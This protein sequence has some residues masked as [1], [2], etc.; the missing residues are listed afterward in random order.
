MRIYKY[1]LGDN[2]IVEITMPGSSKIL[3]VDSQFNSGFLW[4]LVNDYSETEVRKFATYNTG[5]EIPPEFVDRYIGTYMTYDGN[6]VLHVFE[7][8]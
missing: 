1:S 2:Y 5:E 7:I 8:T 4:V 6:Y 3:K